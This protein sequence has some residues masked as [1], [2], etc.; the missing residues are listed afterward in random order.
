MSTTVVMNGP[1]MIAGSMWSAR[2]RSGSAVPASD[3][4]DYRR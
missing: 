3:Y 2:A 4:G 1:D